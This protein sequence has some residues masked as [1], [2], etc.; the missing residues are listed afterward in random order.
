MQGSA[1]DTKPRGPEYFLLGLELGLIGGGDVL[2]WVE[3][4][5]E[6][7]AKP[8]GWLVDLAYLGPTDV[9]D[10]I[11]ILRRAASKFD[12]WTVI[13]ELVFDLPASRTETVEACVAIV[14]GLYRIWVEH[15]CEAPADF[16]D[17]PHLE[18]G[19]KLAKAG[20]HGTVPEWHLAVRGFLR[21]VS[22]STARGSH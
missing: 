6:A 17:L 8:A 1:V 18:D 12:S 5:I 11:S 15:D 9:A 19:Y 16:D 22:R 20:I 7:D 21:A 2:S 14:S 10:M 13:R 4:C 3:S